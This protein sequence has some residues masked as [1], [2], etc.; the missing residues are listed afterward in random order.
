M[1][2]VRAL[3]NLQGLKELVLNGFH[4]ESWAEYLR[5]R[6]GA[7]VQAVHGDRWHSRSRYRNGDEIIEREFARYQEGTEDLIP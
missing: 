4:V 2:V 1:R 6:T 5:K 7:K 3:G